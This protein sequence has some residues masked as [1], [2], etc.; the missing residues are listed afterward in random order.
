MTKQI[1]DSA[2]VTKVNQQNEKKKKKKG[3][4][5]LLEYMEYRSLCYLEL[6]RNPCRCISILMIAWFH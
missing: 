3:R 1:D 6:R 4:K 2:A 5:K